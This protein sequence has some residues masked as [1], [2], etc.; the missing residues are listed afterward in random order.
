[1]NDT[2]QACYRVV[3]LTTIGDKV[4]EA[5]KWQG[6]DTRELSKAYPPSDI[7]GADE[8]DHSEVED[9][10]FRFD[11]RFEQFVDGAWQEIEDPRVRLTPMT[12]L[13]RAIDEENRR[14]YPGDYLDD[15]DE[16][17]YDY[18][19]VDDS[20]CS[21][22]YG[23]GCDMCDPRSH[24]SHCSSQLDGS[25]LFVFNDGL[26]V[27]C[28]EQDKPRCAG[29]GDVLSSDR[30]DICLCLDCDTYCSQEEPE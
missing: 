6:D 10:H 23:Y 13:E 15:D 20:L 11:Y 24:C 9:G 22:C 19:D 26:C 14:L 28:R 21:G 27:L 2:V 12:D 3:A 4:S 1:M 29:C 8:L 5:I 25:D 30:V 16:L 18:D 7:W 17:E